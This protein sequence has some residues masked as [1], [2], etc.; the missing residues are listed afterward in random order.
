MQAIPCI[1]I[2]LLSKTAIK[3]ALITLYNLL[4]CKK[5][6]YLHDDVQTK[7]SKII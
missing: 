6:N 4:L 5:G 2:F 1:V 3:S 7:Q